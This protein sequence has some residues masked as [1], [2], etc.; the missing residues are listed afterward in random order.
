MK[1]LA[2]EETALMGDYEGHIRGIV[3]D[4]ADR[5]RRFGDAL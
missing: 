5:F 1:L 2:D 4:P 3:L